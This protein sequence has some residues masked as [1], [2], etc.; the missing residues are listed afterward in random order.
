MRVCP[1]NVINPALAEAGM[2]AIYLKT[3]KVSRSDG[4][5]FTVQLPYAWTSSCA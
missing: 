2:K 5:E 3:E 4:R 1:T